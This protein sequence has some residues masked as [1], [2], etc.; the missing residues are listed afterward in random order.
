MQIQGD[1]SVVMI[2]GGSG[3]VGSHAIE[4]MLNESAISSIYSLGR[5]P[6][7]SN[8]NTDGSKLIELI[9]PDLQINEWDESRPS[10]T[11][12][13]I[14]LGT[15]IKQAGSNEALYKVDYEL[16]CHVAQTMHLLG[17]KRLAVVSS[18]GA[19]TQ[20]PSHYLRCK[21][22]ME[23]TLT[24]MG[25]EQLLILRPGPL[26]GERKKPRLDEK[27]LQMI[28]WLF[29]PLM[30]GRLKSLV[31]IQAHDVAK[32]ALY[33]LFSSKYH[34]TEMYDSKKMLTFLSEYR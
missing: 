21:G 12:G 5:S 2:A 23:Q 3:L 7:P 15:T 29:R 1:K 4:L 27:W 6:L 19:S 22:Q 11:L 33:K 16:V 30:L 34:P 25:F 14:C 17:V 26:V 18:Y 31:P 10:P 13:L 8:W 32:T 24:R 20:S 28:L 9:S